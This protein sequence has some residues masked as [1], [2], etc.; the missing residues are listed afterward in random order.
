M[1]NRDGKLERVF[2]MKGTIGSYSSLRRALRF[3]LLIS[4]ALWLPL[5]GPVAAEPAEKPLPSLRLLQVLRPPAAVSALAWNSDGS[6]LAGVVLLGS[7][8]IPTFPAVSL[9]SPFGKRITIWNADGSVFRELERPETAFTLGD[10][11][12]FVAGDTQIAAPPLMASQSLAFSVYDVA[13]GA[14][15]REVRGPLPDTE[16]LNRGQ[17]IT[18]SPDQSILALAYKAELPVALY[19]AKDWSK[20]ADLSEDPIKPRGDVK[21]LSFS[22]DGRFLAVLIGRVIR[23]YDVRSTQVIQRIAI[24]SYLKNVALSP[25]GAK[26]AVAVNVLT[27]DGPDS[28]IEVFDVRDASRTATYP[29]GRHAI[30][31][32]E[33][34]PDGRLIAFITS[35]RTLHVWDPARSEKRE[36]TVDL[37][38][39]FVFAFSPD[40]RRIAAKSNDDTVK[41]FDTSW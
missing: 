16:R 5:S 23:I 37:G 35:Y 36:R 32:L 17:L 22:R 9:A 28:S 39:S 40:G 14:V 8:L 26:L 24:N 6:K 11:I 34:S 1:A 10:R 15:V 31:G 4:A 12:A 18:A 41:I 3:V 30:S 38:G 25:D 20:L 7:S 21:D 29:A 13:S 33:W 27:T 19:S 2:V